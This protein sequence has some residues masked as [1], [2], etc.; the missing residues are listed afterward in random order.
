MDANDRVLAIGKL[1]GRSNMEIRHGWESLA[2]ELAAGYSGFD[3]ESPCGMVGRYGVDM[4]LRICD[5]TET[6]G[7]L[8]FVGYHDGSAGIGVDEGGG[9]TL[10]VVMVDDIDWE[11]VS[12]DLAAAQ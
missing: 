7:S 5:M 11:L 12:E 2:G 8:W 3:G 4:V 9:E 6:G 10:T 1:T